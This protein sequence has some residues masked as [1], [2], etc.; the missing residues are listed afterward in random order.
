MDEKRP[1]YTLGK[2]RKNG[3]NTLSAP[4][5]K[6]AKNSQ[7]RKTA[8]TIGWK[9]T[10]IL[11]EWNTYNDKQGAPGYSLKKQAG[12]TIYGLKLWEQSVAS[13]YPTY[14][15]SYLYEVWLVV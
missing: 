10:V 15:E 7:R 11:I 5:L 6:V 1:K 12:E 9:N 13:I 8:K 4:A 2:S 3:K 14:F